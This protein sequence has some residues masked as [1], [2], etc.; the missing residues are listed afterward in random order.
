[1]NLKNSVLLVVIAVIG[2]LSVY[3]FKPFPELQYKRNV[4]VVSFT[5]LEDFAKQLL[6]DVPEVHIHTLIDCN[7]DPHSFHPHPKIFVLLKQADVMVMNGLDFE[8]WFAVCHEHVLGRL[9][10]ASDGI[11]PLRQVHN[12][13]LF[14]PHAWLDVGNAMIYVRNM[15]DAF[16][17]TYPSFAEIIERNYQCFVKDLKQLDAWIPQQFKNLKD[18]TI[19]T[20][21]DAFW[22]YG[23][24]YGVQFI[25][26]QGI[27]TEE[28]ISAS[29]MAQIIR[30]I[31][32]RHVK[33]LFLE[34]LANSAAIRQLA[35]ETKTQIGGTL[36]ADSLSGPGGPC[37]TY[38]TMMQHNTKNIQKAL[39][40]N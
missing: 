35:E 4:V 32:Q 25:S 13:A 22:Y 40:W 29:K 17:K 18:R 30:I 6:K 2:L 23:K 16:K 37:P 38:I 1:M 28:E 14:D 5:I 19:I 31:K 21:H 11:I 24:S 36:Y 10:I 39:S 7:Q 20:T 33:A 8:P 15:R 34:N 12:P 27:N 9:V 3:S 26:P